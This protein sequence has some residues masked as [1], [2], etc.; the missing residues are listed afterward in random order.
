MSKD[1]RKRMG[2]ETE[3]VY[4]PCKLAWEKDE[5]GNWTYTAEDGVL[6]TVEGCC[7]REDGVDVMEIVHRSVY[8]AKKWAEFSIE[9]AAAAG[10]GN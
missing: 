4:G 9:C 5:D 2:H 1:Y 6:W 8:G 10:D 3:R 7:V